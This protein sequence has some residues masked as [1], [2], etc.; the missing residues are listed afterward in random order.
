MSVCIDS[1]H[2]TRIFNWLNLH[3]ICSTNWMKLRSKKKKTVSFADA[4]MAEFNFNNMDKFDM[5]WNSF[6]QT[7]IWFDVVLLEWG[8]LQ[9]MAYF[10]L[11]Q[12]CNWSNRF[13][14]STC[15]ALNGTS[16]HYQSTRCEENHLLYYF[17]M[18]NKIDSTT[19]CTHVEGV[20]VFRDPPT[21]RPTPTA[22][23][24]IL[25]QS[26]LPHSPPIYFQTCFFF[27]SP[28]LLTPSH[29]N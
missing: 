29:R 10:R 16:F 12:F 13:V 2:L 22:S 3:S 27:W 6:V 26:I 14:R 25:M 28:C 5:R 23:K 21:D 4:L 8:V 24:S 18:E 19:D 15:G 17:P 9:L 1:F 20:R 7:I 11:Y